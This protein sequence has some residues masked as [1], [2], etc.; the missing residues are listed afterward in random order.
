MRK[1]V[2]ILVLVVLAGVGWILLK[3]FQIQGLEQLRLVPKGEGSLLDGP[4][5]SPESPRPVASVGRAQRS[6][7]RG[8][9]DT[10]NSAPL[11]RVATFFVEGFGLTKAKKPQVMDILARIGREFEVLAIQ[12]ITSESDDIVPRLVDLMNKTG[13]H[14][15]YAVGPRVGPPGGEQQFAFIFDS[16]AVVLD[17]NELYTVD[18]HD[19]LLSYEPLVGW[20][21]TRG[22]PAEHA[23]TFS[24]VNV[25]VDRQKGPQERNVLDDVLRAV[26]ND[27]RNEDD[28][29]LAGALFA[30]PR[31]LGELDQLAD[32]T[33]AV[34]DVP[35]DTEGTETRD[36][37]ILQKSATSEYTGR[38]GV[39]DFLR[40]YNLSLAAA[41]EVSD[42][43]PV[44]AEFHLIEGGE[45]GRV[46]NAPADSQMRR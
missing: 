39:L 16:E 42:H 15:D 32:V 34:M 19:D 27:G 36:N 2:I 11:V 38:S 45:P 8:A 31:L 1:P 3:N 29:I 4:S 14:F 26:R 20:F 10:Q 23:F 33:Y 30:P 44:W 5:R 43:L 40:Q 22:P 18:D 46:A 28:V 21:K 17:R 13:R 25:R 6:A 37:L 24:L 35:T 41:L 9:T 7:V 12:D